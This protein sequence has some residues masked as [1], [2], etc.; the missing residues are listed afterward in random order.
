[1]SPA[2][3][4]FGRSR[5]FTIVQFTDT[6]FS[7]SCPRDARTSALMAEVLD[8]ERPDLVVLTGDVVSGD[9]SPDPAAAWRAAGAPIA[10]CLGPLSS[11]T[12]TTKALSIVPGFS[13]RSAGSAG[14]SRSRAHGASAVSATT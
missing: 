10:S 2:P 12:T 13:P 5:R 11:A 9:Q 1:V 8:A 4:R 14:A 7:R 6:H 3:L